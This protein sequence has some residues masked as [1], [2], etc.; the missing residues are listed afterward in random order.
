MDSKDWQEWLVISNKII[1]SAAFPMWKCNFY[2][3]IKCQLGS[4]ELTCA[5]RTQPS[6]FIHRKQPQV[7]F[8]WKLFLSKQEQIPAQGKSS[9]KTKVKIRRLLSEQR[10]G[11]NGILIG[12]SSSKLP[13]SSHQTGRLK[14]EHSLSQRMRHGLKC[15]LFI[16]PF[17]MSLMYH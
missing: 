15:L 14:L 7:H 11:A 10:F 2:Q 16:S 5:D 9:Q 8:W 6:W 17:S 1:W 13:S 3:S 4:W 12:I